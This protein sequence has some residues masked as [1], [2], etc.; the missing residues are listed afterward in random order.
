MYA[1]VIFC[2]ALTKAIVSVNG[3]DVSVATDIGTIVG[4]KETLSWNDTKLTLITFEGIPYA[5]PTTGTR[6]FSKPIKKSPFTA[7]FRADAMPPICYQ[8]LTGVE[9]YG[10]DPESLRL[11]EDCLYLSIYIPGGPINTWSSRAVMIWIY[12]GGFQF[13]FQDWFDAKAF[14]ALN[15]VILVTI[16]YRVTAFGFFSTWENNLS[17]NYG[18]WDQHMAIKWV[19]DHIDKFGGDPNSVTIFGESAGSLS[20][21]YQ[22]LYEGNQGLFQRVIAQS[23]SINNGWAYQL[24]PHNEYIKSAK[25]NGCFNESQ[26]TT[27]KCLRDIP[28]ENVMAPMDFPSSFLPVKDGE[29]VKVAPAEVFLNKTIVSSELLHNFGKYDLIIGF[30][31]AEGAYM[32]GFTDYIVQQLGEDPSL[33]Y[34]LGLFES[35]AIPL[36]SV[37]SYLESSPPLAASIVHEYT[38]WSDPTN[39]LT[40]LQR[41]VDMFSD[42]MYNAGIIKTAHSHSTNQEESERFSTCLITRPPCQTIATQGLNMVMRLPTCWGSHKGTGL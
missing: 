9:A 8:N 27:I 26:L 15:D 10:V 1:C 24:N 32:L 7:P 20:V 17:G 35:T 22:A 18:L 5:E 13:G 21:I 30:N 38:E 14:A 12:G 6:R 19:H 25:I 23:G 28:A 4:Q 33:G 41:T 36:A 40:M 29:F 34:S 2:L 39:K 3:Q 11:S 31:S 37:H 42:S 16:N